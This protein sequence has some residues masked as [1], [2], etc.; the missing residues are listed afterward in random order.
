M[1]HSGPR[2]QCWGESPAQPKRLQLTSCPGHRLGFFCCTSPSTEP[3]VGRCGLAGLARSHDFKSRTS[4]V[5]LAGANRPA[6]HCR[7]HFVQKTVP[8]AITHVA[9]TFCASRSRQPWNAFVLTLHGEGEVALADKIFRP[10]LHPFEV[11]L[12]E[13]AKQCV[14]SA[15]H[16]RMIP[17][18][19]GTAA[20]R[21]RPCEKS[22]APVSLPSRSRRPAERRLAPT[23]FSVPLREIPPPE[24]PHARPCLGVHPGVRT[25]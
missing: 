24:S 16:H 5:W 15:I 9:S 19:V 14:A 11:K 6:S 4:V 18:R 25:A 17:N 2:C 21:I 10:A 23:G 3:S 13:H 12:L 22:S 1:A 7:G 8:H 20:G